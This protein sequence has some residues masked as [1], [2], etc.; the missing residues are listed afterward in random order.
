MC[1]KQDLLNSLPDYPSVEKVIFSIL[2]SFFSPKEISKYHKLLI[3]FNCS[4]I[5]GEED[6]TK[7]QLFKDLFHSGV[8]GAYIAKSNFE[9]EKGKFISYAYNYIKHEIIENYNLNKRQIS[10]SLN[11]NENREIIKISKN[12]NQQ[13]LK[14]KD[15]IKLK[16]QYF[17]NY[18]EYSTNEEFENSSISESELDN[19]ILNSFS[20][21]KL[22]VDDAFDLNYLINKLSHKDREVLSARYFENKTLEDIAKNNGVSKEAIRKVEIRA[23]KNLQQLV[24]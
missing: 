21:N 22:N 12:E 1:L 23:I 3:S 9:K 14:I 18:K 7:F 13:K 4:R 11:N 20:C 6:H 24:K 17:T 19:E 5:T 8:M 2:K 15:K 10:F 16:T